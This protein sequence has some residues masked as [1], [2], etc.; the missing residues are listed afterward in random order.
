MELR[1]LKERAEAGYREKARRGELYV[2][3]IAVGYQGT[4]YGL[5][6]DPDKRV[7]EAIEL[8]FSKF[9]E[10]GSLNKTCKWFRNNGILCPVVIYEGGESST[11]W[12]LRIFSN[13]CISRLNTWLSRKNLK[14][15]LKR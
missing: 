12:K 8:I 2:G 4:K 6:K 14:S 15:E 11:D 7:Q 1:V 13:S 9:D 5:R 3:R 10:L